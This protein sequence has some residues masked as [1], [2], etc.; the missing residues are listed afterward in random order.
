M[1]RGFRMW[2]CGE[3][4]RLRGRVGLGGKSLIY[5]DVGRCWLQTDRRV[6]NHGY[7]SCAYMRTEAA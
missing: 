2:V 4:W 5:V 6:R 3:E 1:R 7:R